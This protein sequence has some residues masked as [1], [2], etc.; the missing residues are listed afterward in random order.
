MASAFALAIFSGKIVLLYEWKMTAVIF[1]S[2]FHKSGSCRQTVSPHRTADSFSEDRPLGWDPVARRA[3]GRA[4]GMACNSNDR[5]QRRKQRVAV[6]AAASKTQVPPK[7]RCGC[8]V[9]QP[10]L[11]VRRESCQP[12]C[13]F[14]FLL[15]DL[16]QMLHAVLEAVEEGVHVL[17]GVVG[18]EGHPDGGIDGK[19]VAPHG[20]SVWLGWPRPQ[21]LAEET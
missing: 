14:S 17:R 10:V 6:G 18:A 21:A 11:R 2:P 8:W 12:F 9:P 7:A 5:R 4:M 15:S 16:L 3:I 1:H 20:A 19:R 13:G